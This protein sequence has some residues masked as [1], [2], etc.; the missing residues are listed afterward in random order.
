MMNVF[1][2]KK[3]FFW[4]RCI[5]S[6]GVLIYLFTLLQ[7]SRFS[8]VVLH[9]NLTYVWIAP[10]L[11]LISFYFAAIRWHLLLSSLQIYQ[12]ISQSFR[13]YL[14]GS[15]Y[16][17]VL[18]GVIGGDAIRISMSAL[19]QKQPFWSIALSV[20]IERILGL[21]VLLIIGSFAAPFIPQD[22]INQWG[23]S[24]IKVLYTTT[25]IVLVVSL[26]VYGLIQITSEIWLL[27]K[28]NIK[29]LNKFSQILISIKKIAPKQLIFVALGTALFQSTDI[30]TSFILAKSLGISL[31]LSTF[32]VVI[33]IVSV[34]TLLPIS[35]GGLG[36]REGVL[37]YL[38]SK[39]GVI[40]ADAV[41]C[42]LLIYTNRLLVS[43]I[44]GIIQLLGKA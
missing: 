44:G 14:V 10:V 17:I 1:H 43:L 32:F 2:L 34:V 8:T 18:P 29:V 25:S 19:N 7:R 24:I 13:I 41:L 40:P 30:I 33:P 4:I 5:F 23:V 12:S 21:I 27:E 6:T 16:S 42:S 11:I 39:I 26:M 20:L 9:T 38:L 3:V 15:F 35:L 22:F 37:T 28:V 36:V 31:P